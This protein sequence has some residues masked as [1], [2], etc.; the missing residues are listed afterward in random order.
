VCVGH[1]PDSCEF[2]TVGGWIA[3][4]ASG[5]KKNIYG[6]IEDIVLS[7][8]LVTPN[9]VL[10]RRGNYKMA[11]KV[12]AEHQDLD[13][14]GRKLGSTQLAESGVQPA[15]EQDGGAV[16][17]NIIPRMS[18]GMDPTEI[19]LGSEGTLGI[20]TKVKFKLR[21]LPKAREF[22]AIIFKT[23]EE[24]VGFMREVARKHAAP[25]SIRLVDN[26]QFVFG[27]A[28]K[29]AGGGMLHAIVDAV[30]KVYVVNIS[31]FDPNNMCA[32]TLLMEGDD[33]T[34]EAECSQIY[35][36]AA[37]HGGMK[38]DRNNGIR[39]YFL[40]YSIAYLRDFGLGYWFMAESFET[41]IAWSAILPMTAAVKDKMEEVAHRFGVKAHTHKDPCYEFLK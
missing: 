36:I 38:A 19:A 23:M 20:V 18:A 22:G 6:N 13:R 4:R 21:D 31:G 33:A 17:G 32:C 40:T 9:G 7:V 28:L 11:A 3:T 14:G 12:K 34:V 35:S 27:Q 25:A 8:N 1:E 24:G 15:N 2:S 5:M 10:S 37:K 30:K 16:G 29:P 39:G 26:A 41:S